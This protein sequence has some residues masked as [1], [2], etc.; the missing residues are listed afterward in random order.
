MTKGAL[1][2]LKP[3]K[4]RKFNNIED[5][6]IQNLKHGPTIEQTGIYDIYDAS[7]II[8]NYNQPLPE[9]DYVSYDF[10]S[11]FINIT[12]KATNYYILHENQITEPRMLNIL[13]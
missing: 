13:D 5:S 9:N 10:E 1:F 4:T 8:A 3:L 12:A 6:W 11:F 7:K 2:L